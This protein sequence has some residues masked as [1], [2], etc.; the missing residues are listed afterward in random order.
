MLKKIWHWLCSL[1]KKG[2]TH[3]FPCAFLNGD[4][5]THKTP[6]GFDER[7]FKL[8]GDLI[9]PREDI[10]FDGSKMHPF[11]FPAEAYTGTGGCRR[12]IISS[13]DLKIFKEK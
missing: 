4:F 5:E 2:E 7:Y 6:G 10:E 3:N 9:L 8:V 11:N 12:D 13:D 1:R